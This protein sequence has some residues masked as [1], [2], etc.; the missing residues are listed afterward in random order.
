MTFRY[1]PRDLAEIGWITATSSCAGPS[2][3]DIADAT[4]SMQDLQAAR[5]QRRR[6]LR[7][8]LNARWSLADL[9]NHPQPVTRSR[10]A[11]P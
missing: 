11:A 2:P 6:E 1:D 8:H 4:I 5:N 7:E 9:L 3:P 10:S